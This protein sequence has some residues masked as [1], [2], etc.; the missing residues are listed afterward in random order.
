MKNIFRPA[1]NT[2]THYMQRS[3]LLLSFD[4]NDFPTDA[5]FQGARVTNPGSS[6]IVR[7]RLYDY[8]LYPTAGQG[9]L[10]FFTTAQGS[11]ITTAAG[12]TVGSTKT[13]QDTNMQGAGGQLSSGLGYLIE[14]IEVL[15]L[16]GSVSTANTY[17][18]A[19]LSLF[20]AAAAAT[21]AGQLNDVNTFYQS[22]ML[23]FRVLQ[24]NALQEAPLIAFPPK[25]HL[26]LSAALTSNSATAGL[27]A[28]VLA[29]AAGRPYYLEPRVSLQSA[30]NFGVTLEWPA[31]VATPSGFNARVGVIFDGYMQRAGQ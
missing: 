27:T 26:D 13:A 19:N 6:E 23:T 1:F 25:A 10:N 9:Q 30:V 18:P 29:K 24:K 4:S 2:L 7:Q 20:A 28:A 16:P 11:G 31:P 12:A 5:D 22:G 15:Y 21:V 8:Q 17:T 14:S 3:G